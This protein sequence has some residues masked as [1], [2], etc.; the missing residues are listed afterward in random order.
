[1][2]LKNK[3]P[4]AP[5]LGEN[6][7]PE[8][9]DFLWV[10][11][12]LSHSL[13][14]F[15]PS[16]PVKPRPKLQRPNLFAGFLA[17]LALGFCWSNGSAEEPCASSAQVAEIAPGVFVRPGR[18]EVVFEAAE[19]ANLGFV[20]GERCVAVIDTGGSYAEG[21]ALRC[22]IRRRSDLPVCFVI[23]THVHPDHIL[24]NLAFESEQTSF[25][26]HAKLPRALALRGDIY[27]ERAAAQAG[28]RVGPEHIVA[29]DRTVEESL[30]LD[31]GNRTLRVTAHPT[32]H[33]DNDV[34][35]LDLTTDT[36]F[37]GDL[38]F[39][40]HVPVL[41]GSLKGWLEVLGTLMVQPARRVVPGHGPAQAEWP[42]AGD[43]TVRYLS[44][45]GDETRK[46][47]ASGGDLRGAQSQVGYQ[48]APHWL[49]FERHHKRN[50]TAAVNEIE[51]EE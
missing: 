50:V 17:V 49:L 40:R 5:D 42:V 48:E 8:R 27:L 46:W 30:D 29:P 36:L 12:L 26:G 51:W 2:I 43:D 21:E 47:L 3:E 33:T 7:P 35:V 4:R 9:I 13:R 38:V 1:M 14:H 23:N 41:D 22:A 32:A 31:L 18:H 37:L 28:G 45:L 25:V 24:G 6:P 10:P 19:I 39:M 34:S 11:T 20:I 15:V 16:R 44:L